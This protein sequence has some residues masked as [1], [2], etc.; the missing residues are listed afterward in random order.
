VQSSA[1]LG[2]DGTIYVGSTD[3]KLYAFHPD[4][5]PNGAP[6]PTDGDIYSSPAIAEDGTIYV[7][8]VD[9]YLYALNPPS[10]DITRK[11]RAPTGGPVVSSPAVGSDGTVYVGSND[12][13]LYAF[14][15]ADGSEFWRYST[16]DYIGWS[17]PA[18]G[19]DGTIYIGSMDDY[20]Y[21]IKSNGTF[22]W[23]FPLR[24]DV[25]HSAS[26]APDG[27]VYI[28]SCGDDFYALDPDDGSSI[29]SQGMPGDVDSSPALGRDGTIYVL[30]D[31]GINRPGYLYAFNPDGSLHWPDLMPL[32]DVAEDTAPAIGSDGLIY[33]GLDNGLIYAVEDRG[34]EG[35]VKWSLR[36]GASEPGVRNSPSIGPDGTLYVGSY[37]NR[38]YA[39]KAGFQ[40]DL[41]IRNAGE[42]EA[43]YISDDVYNVDGTDQTKTQTVT[44]STPAVYELKVQNDGAVDDSFTVTGSPGG[45]GWTV[46]YYDALSGGTDITD[47]V[48]GAGWS[49]NDLAARAS[50][51]FR[52]EVTP[53][54]TVAG[55]AV[56]DVLVT[57]TSV[58]DP[59]KK[60]LVKASTTV[61]TRQPDMLIRNVGETTYTG[62]NV[63]NS[64]GTNQTKVRR[65]TEP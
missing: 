34:S 63:Y 62:D 6:Y 36:T 37:D 11:W 10:P 13:S 21:A 45:D 38:L 17:S 5:T 54:A 12:G 27:T 40:P 57:A 24:G 43:D 35:R 56:K 33:F 31:V 64:T 1:A 48:T 25:Q 4:G 49:V 8:S 52:V 32:D 30:C 20:L 41:L 61:P 60:D 26:V 53:D 3:G 58:G 29:W 19:P 44:N 2:S 15:P 9:G 65:T 23:R 51:E 14:D 42:G 50:V 55:D 18:L 22:K 16:G 47:Q 7:G 39:I 59:T 46:T 28:G